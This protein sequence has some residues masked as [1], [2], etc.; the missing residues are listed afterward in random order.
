MIASAKALRRS[1][2]VAEADCKVR[3]L[4][5]GEASIA[6]ISVVRGTA[7]VWLVGAIG[8]L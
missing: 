6:L 3:R 7:D 8:Y 1:I 5:T 2:I 4:K